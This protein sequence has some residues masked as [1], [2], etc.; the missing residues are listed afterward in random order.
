VTSAPQVPKA[1]TT[2]WLIVAYASMVAA[3][4][5][6]CA[7]TW[8]RHEFL[9]YRC[10]SFKTEIT[11][12][13]ITVYSRTSPGKLTVLR[14]EYL[15]RGTDQIFFAPL[16]RQRPAKWMACVYETHVTEIFPA[17]GGRENTTRALGVLEDLAVEVDREWRSNCDLVEA[18]VGQ[19]GDVV[20]M[21]HDRATRGA[22]ACELLTKWEHYLEEGRNLRKAMT[23]MRLDVPSGSAKRNVPSSEPART[24][25]SGSSTARDRNGV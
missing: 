1:R 10:G 7:L 3:C 8:E 14:Q 17:L 5:V 20:G 13:G 21:Y 15:G 9:G 4:V 22:A 11:C 18:F 16:G 23:K 6:V 19:C 2:K 24:V 25:Q 12:L